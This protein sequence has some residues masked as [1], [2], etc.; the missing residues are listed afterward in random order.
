M[1]DVW[2]MSKDRVCTLVYLAIVLVVRPH[3]VGAAEELPS[4]SIWYNQVIRRTSHKKCMIARALASA[5]VHDL[6]LAHV[7]EPEQ[8][9]AGSFCRYD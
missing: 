3:D 8:E 4:C 9:G 6:A 5:G 2:G 1:S 7:S